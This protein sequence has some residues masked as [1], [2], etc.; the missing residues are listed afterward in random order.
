MF[1]IYSYLLAQIFFSFIEITW[2]NLR[3]KGVSTFSNL[4]IFTFSIPLFLILGIILYFNSTISITSTYI[5][6]LLIWLFFDVIN[7]ILIV[8]LFKYKSL[9]ELTSYKLTFSTIVAIFVD[10]F[11]LKFQ[12]NF[13]TFSSVFFFFLSSY[14]LT[15]NKIEKHFLSRKIS[16]SIIAILS[17]IQV[18]DYFL[19]KKAILIQD[20]ILFHVVLS[21]VALFIIFFIIG[22]ESLRKDISNKKINWK[23]IV[24]ITFFIFLAAILESFAFKELPVAIL[25]LTAIFPILIYSIYDMKTSEIKV[26]KTTFIALLSLILGIVFLSIT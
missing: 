23:H 5:T 20:S 17:V 13:F 4:S 19:Y 16:I 15:K 14:L 3:N 8:Y 1:E 22:Q 25:L 24:I 6:I 21:Q 9:L 26:T 7:N 2:K 12:Y 18:I 11:Y 10:I